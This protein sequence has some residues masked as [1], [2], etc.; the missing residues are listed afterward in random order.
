MSLE[1]HSSSNRRSVERW[2]H[3]TA[4]IVGFA[5]DGKMTSSYV[6]K[7]EKGV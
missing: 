3:E 4:Y 1:S 2:N 7:Y 5:R 6:F